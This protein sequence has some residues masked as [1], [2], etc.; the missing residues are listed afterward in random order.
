[1][2]A[3]LE[4]LADL[5]PQLDPIPGWKRWWPSPSA[6]TRTMYW[7]LHQL[8]Q[9]NVHI[10]QLSVD[11][12]SGRCTL[13]LEKMPSGPVEICYSATRRAQPVRLCEIIVDE[14]ALLHEFHRDREIA[15][16][17]QLL[18]STLIITENTVTGPSRGEVAKENAGNCQHR[19]TFSW[20]DRLGRTSRTGRGIH[21]R[22]R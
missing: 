19:R 3:A 21:L 1:M 7:R 22:S 15:R 14:L 8:A 6:L 10:M 12:A 16:L 20:R 4:D 11:H 13:V 9:A 5:G 2:G 17:N 18:A